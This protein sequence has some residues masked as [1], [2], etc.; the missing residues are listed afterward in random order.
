MFSAECESI[1]EIEAFDWP[2]PDYL[3]FS[4]SKRVAKA[5]ISRDMAVFSGMWAPFFH[6]MCDF[7]GME[8][9]FMKMYTHPTVIEAAT[10]R[11]LNFYL[12][13]NQ[14]CFESYGDHIDAVFFGNDLGSQRNP[15]ISP[16][17]LRQF[18]LPGFRK[19]VD[20]AKSYGLKVVLHSCG[21]N[22]KHHPGP[23]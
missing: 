7:F 2:N 8:N 20:Q 17:A 9:Y 6:E 11:I 1:A 14:R 22:I 23:D 18:V 21:A 19:I 12:A 10:E 5:A 13:A 15:L 4:Y 3:D 16:D